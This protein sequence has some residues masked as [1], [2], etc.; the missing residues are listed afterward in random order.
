MGKTIE[1]R[2]DELKDA[3]YEANWIA[4]DKTRVDIIKDW[5]TMLAALCRLR[6]N[7]FHN[8]ELDAI[9]AKMEGKE[10]RGGFLDTALSI[11]EEY[12]PA[13]I[14]GDEWELI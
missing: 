13:D 6:D 1:E 10:K 12:D 7:L 14:F 9:I 8:S 11:D 4:V 5:N 2:L 3:A